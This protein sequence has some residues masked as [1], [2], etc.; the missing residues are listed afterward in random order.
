[1]RT[2]INPDPH[3]RSFSTHPKDN[4]TA[5]ID[6]LPNLAAVVRSLNHAGF[7]DKQASIFM[8][9]NRG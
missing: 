3:A 5:V 6:E 7:F 4:V 9:R 8:G 1:M 2:K